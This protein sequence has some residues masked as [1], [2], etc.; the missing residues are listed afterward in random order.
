MVHGTFRV[1]LLSL[2][3]V[4][5]LTGEPVAVLHVVATSA[6]QPITW[7]VAGPGV[8]A[9]AAGGELSFSARSAHRVHHARRAD[10]VRER[11]LSAP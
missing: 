6:P 4:Y 3:R 8:S 5:E 9:A 11:R 1:V 7:E 10:G 2:P